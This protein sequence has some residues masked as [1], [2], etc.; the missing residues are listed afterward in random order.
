MA[1]DRKRTAQL[2]KTIKSLDTTLSALPD[3]HQKAVRGHLDALSQQYGDL[4]GFDH[5][6]KDIHWLACWDLRDTSAAVRARPAS[7]SANAG[8]GA[9]KKK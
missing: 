2:R 7:T 1:Y 3:K 8:D 5:Q 4:L 6:S 9:K